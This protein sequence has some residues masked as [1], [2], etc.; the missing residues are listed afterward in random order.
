MLV[1]N[2]HGHVR[3]FDARA[4]TLEAS[5]TDK[6]FKS[7]DAT[8]QY[9]FIDSGGDSAPPAGV[10]SVDVTDVK[11][12]DGDVRL[13]LGVGEEDG[14]FPESTGSLTLKGGKRVSFKILTASRRASQIKVR[15]SVDDARE[16]DRVLVNL[17]KPRCFG[18]DL[19][20]APGSLGGIAPKGYVFADGVKDAS[21]APVVTVVSPIKAMK[22]GA[23]YVLSN[24]GSPIAGAVVESS[25][26]REVTLRIVP[27]PLNPAP[28]AEA[29][30]RARYVLPKVTHPFCG[31]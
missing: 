7:A 13:T 5:F 19:I 17:R 12:E 23:A 4:T 14:V 2:G 18:P 25:N 21:K 3:S 22:G 26:G 16:I 10:A 1:K 24:S 9:V 27:I 6:G 11:P 31:D 20:D 29:L 30:G 15:L 8:G 28:N